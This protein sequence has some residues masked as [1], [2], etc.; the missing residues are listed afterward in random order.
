MRRHS[1]RP[2]MAAAGNPLRCWGCMVGSLIKTP[3]PSQGETGGMISCLTGIYS[4]RK[5]AAD[6]TGRQAL[7]DREPVGSELEHRQE[8]IAY[9]RSRQPLAAIPS[10]F[11]E[12]APRFVEF[13]CTLASHSVPG[14]LGG[15]RRNSAAWRSS[16]RLFSI[17]TVQLARSTNR[18]PMK[19]RGLRLPDNKSRYPHRHF[20][21]FRRRRGLQMDVAE[22]HALTP[23]SFAEEG[24]GLTHRYPGTWAICG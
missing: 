7:K 2:S 15:S 22:T 19:I 20:T 23:L 5:L 12:P 21:P 1:R 16:C 8:R 13:R 4:R 24:S 17:L 3:G 11:P 6:P 9:S 14:L 18:A 10:R